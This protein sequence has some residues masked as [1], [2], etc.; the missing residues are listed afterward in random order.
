VK[1]ALASSL[2]EQGITIGKNIIIII[3]KTAH[4]KSFAVEIISLQTAK[5]YKIFFEKRWD[6]EV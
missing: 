3:I 1:I 2:L 5:S 6:I 4:P